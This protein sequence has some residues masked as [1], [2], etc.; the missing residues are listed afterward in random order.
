MVVASESMQKYFAELDAKLEKT[1]LMANAARKKGYDPE[2][3]ADIPLARNMAERVEGLISAVAPQLVGKGVPER[4]IELEKKYGAL[5]WQV[6]LLIAEEVAAEKFCAFK[7]KKEAIEI[8][9]RTGFTYHTVGIVSA[10][11]EGFVELRIKKRKDGKEYFAPTFAGPIRGAGGT[12]A[13]VSLIISDYV[14]KKNGYEVYDPD[15]KET[16]RLVT[17]LEDYHERV[18]NLQYHASEDEIEFLAKNLPIEI[19]GEPTEKI[20][21]S[22]Y[23]DL[24]RIETNKIRGGVALVTSMVALKAPKLWKELSKWGKDFGLEHWSFLEQFIKL[25]KEKKSKK[26]EKKGDKEEKKQRITPDYTYIADLVAGRPVLTH[27]LKEGGFRLRYGRSR[28]SGYSSTT[29]HPATSHMLKSY[30]AIGTQLKME[31][32]GKATSLGMCDTIEGPII[33]LLNGS[34]IRIDDEAQA[35]QYVPEI[36]KILFLGDILISYGDFFDRAHVLAP[37]GYCEEFWIQEFEKAAREKYNETDLEKTHQKIADD[38]NVDVARI[39]ALFENFLTEK[40]SAKDIISI[41]KTFNIPLHPRYT[42]HWK[43][44]SG[45]K[46]VEL[47]DWIFRARI[48]DESELHL[49]M[50]LPK[51]TSKDSKETLENIGL[52]HLMG[53]EDIII[54]KDDAETLMELFS[55]TKTT[56]ESIL[57]LKEAA[58]KILAEKKDATALD[59]INEFSKVKMRDKSGIFIGAR[60]GR[61]E[62]AKMR[63]LIGSPHVL[64]PVGDEGGKMRSFQAAIEKGKVTADFP[65]RKCDK[66][67]KET[68]YNICE[69]CNEKS[70]QLYSCKICG[71]KDEPCKAHGSITYTRRTININ[72]FLNSALKMLKTSQYPDLIKGVRGTAN[73]SHV[74]EHLLKG[75]LRAK[76]NLFVNKDGTIRYDMTELPIT[77][78]KPNEVAVSVEKMLELGYDKDIKGNPLIDE[79]QVLEIKPQDVIIPCSSE[80]PDDPAD[81]VMMNVANFVDELLVTFYGQEPFYN[82]KRREDL[83]GHLVIGLAPHISAGMIGR[84]IGFSKTQ[85]CYAHPLWHAAQRR[86]CD[87]DENCILL[88]GDATLNFSRQFLPDK[89][90]GRTMDAPLVLTSILNPAEVDDM[91]HKLDIAWRYP[92]EFYLATLEYKQPWD[93][94]VPQLGGFLGTEKQYEGM[95]FTHGMSNFNAGIRCSAYKFLPTME[96]KLK[97]QMELAERIRAVDESDVARLVIEKHFMKDTKGNLRKFSTQKFRCS[98]CNE[99]FRRPPLVG[100]CTK[101]GGKIIFTISEGSVIKYLEPSISLA[102]KYNVS[103]Y[104]KQTLEILQRRIDGVFGKEKETQAGLGKWFG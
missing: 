25:Q 98:S 66:C 54:E 77:H 63:K 102:K 89:R 84:I 16:K 62:K 33:K 92:L 45:E 70:R 88:L 22:N 35:K 68:P 34:V 101:C 6:A 60:M 82:I 42:Y 1:Y 21:V 96:D 49:K 71:I 59:I 14:R 9:I 26:E 51:P 83:L 86:D 57:K 37:A 61:P 58:Q 47:L 103:P 78:F 10:P 27:P 29:I 3:K 79:D 94:K 85:G 72:E 46:L 8:G 40:P 97:G 90:G 56:I 32:P 20:D 43:L 93:I 17:E 19:D 31:R 64:F 69:T 50:I 41:S 100:K 52:P 81:K 53:V 104:L 87:G 39:K 95:G 73:K 5:S 91:V 67:N 48:E 18:T 13:A 7:D 28:V 4:I 44:V 75:I 12:A 30:I 74:H 65:I 76:H 80:S 99:K 23:K 55:I 2:D 36:S 38:S 15:E 24:P 11:L